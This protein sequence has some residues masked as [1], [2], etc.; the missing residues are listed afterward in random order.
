VV[1]SVIIPAHNEGDRL[2]STVRSIARSRST[3]VA[4]EVIV[5]DDGSTDG[6]CA[7]FIDEAAALSSGDFSVSILTLP[8]HAGNYRARNAG[9][10]AA[11]GDVLVFTDAHVAFS[12]GWDAAILR[13]ADPGWVLAGSV[14]DLRSQ[15]VGSGL[16]L[17][18]PDMWTHWRTSAGAEPA[19]VAAAPCAAMVVCRVPFLDLGGFDEDLRWY[20]GGESEF[21][22]RCWLS[23]L[24]V[25]TCP[26]F[27]VTHA[28][29]P[30]GEYRAQYEGL[31]VDIV[32]NLLRV[33]LLYLDDLAAALML[34]FYAAADRDVFTAAYGMLSISQ[35]RER[36][37]YLSGSLRR[38]FGWLARHFRLTLRNGQPFPG[39]IDAESTTTVALT[40]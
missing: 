32:H 17:V 28:F 26:E 2:S 23:G 34:N 19:E 4:V 36:R 20:G 37:A 9:A 8:E 31:K 33:G 35:V 13:S 12:A 3:A 30:R 11:G 10:R 15:F 29:K 16:K 5:V 6:G 22:I 25:V 38:E 14:A 18:C 7:R 40:S 39:S 24:S 1:I 21:G 27:V